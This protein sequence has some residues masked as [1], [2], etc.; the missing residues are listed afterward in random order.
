MS[1][2]ELGNVIDLSFFILVLLIFISIDLFYINRILGGYKT[3]RYINIFLHS[4]IIPFFITYILLF[5]RTRF[6][7][8]INLTTIVIF[9]L[10]DFIIKRFYSGK[11]NK[12]EFKWKFL[13]VTYFIFFV[14][15]QFVVWMHYWFYDNVM[16]FIMLIF[17]IINYLIFIL[18]LKKYERSKI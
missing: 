13:R 1:T 16:G 2:V 12:R 6:D 8:Y 15:A 18:Y 9:L 4:L 10:L 11:I 3:E 14:V 7:Y 17:I 5:E